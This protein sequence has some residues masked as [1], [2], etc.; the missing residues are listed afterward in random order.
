MSHNELESF[1]DHIT[2]LLNKNGYPDKKVALPLERMYEAAHEKGLNFNKVLELLS[3][4]GISHEKTAEK[5]IFFKSTPPETAAPASGNAPNLQDM[6]A[7]AQEMLKTMSPE[8]LQQ[9]Q[10]LVGKMSPEEK[11]EMIKRAQAMGIG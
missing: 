8:Q 7:K 1:T 4:K 11:A 5:V 2:S 9:I 3:S 6:M 10:D